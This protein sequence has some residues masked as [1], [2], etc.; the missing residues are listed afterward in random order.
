MDGP[1][2]ALI[3]AGR[4][5]DSPHFIPVLDAVRVPRT[6]PGR[7]RSRPDR[8]LADK[9][10]SS[11][12]NRAYLR[13]RKIALTIPVKVDQQANRRALG[14]SGGR[15]PAFD[16]EVYRQRH[17]RARGHGLCSGPLPRGSAAPPPVSSSRR[18]E[19]RGLNRHLLPE[20]ERR[21]RHAARCARTRP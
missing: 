17:G 1:P 18:R 20:A 15:P 16:P 5:G 11:R 2:A 13:R 7:L 3:T 8:V 10:Y 4:R 19:Q 9:A 6:G 21:E 14:S 12:A